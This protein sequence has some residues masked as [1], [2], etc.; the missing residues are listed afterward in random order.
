VDF[1]KRI[2]Y[3]ITESLKYNVLMQYMWEDSDHE[4]MSADHGVKSSAR[5]KKH[6]YDK[7]YNTLFYASHC[8]DVTVHFMTLSIN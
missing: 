6:S 5:C 3:R 2:L 8:Y 1:N 7:A 4:N